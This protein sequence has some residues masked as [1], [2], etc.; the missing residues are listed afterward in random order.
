[1]KLIKDVVLR[2]YQ[3]FFIDLKNNKF[4]P[5]L[6]YDAVS[7][8]N[9]YLSVYKNKSLSDNERAVRQLLLE[10][11][12]YEALLESFVLDR[13]FEDK[14][15]FNRAVKSNYSAHMIPFVQMINDCIS[16]DGALIDSIFKIFKVDRKSRISEKS[17]DDIKLKWSV[18]ILKD[19]V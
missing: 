12:T 3:D 1:M 18:G 19:E 10:G 16:S 8:S 5:E 11:V 14:T 6:F 7:M 2:K 9:A 4:R 17:Y 13:D 15:E